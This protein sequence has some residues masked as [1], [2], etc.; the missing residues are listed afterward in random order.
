MDDAGQTIPP[1]YFQA[2]ADWATDALGR[3]DTK[4]LVHCHAGVNRGPSGAFTVL[5]AQGWGV[6][7]APRRSARPVRSP[8]STTPT[9]PS[10]G[11]VDADDAART[12]A[13]EIVMALAQPSAPSTRRFGR[14]GPTDPNPWRICSGHFVSRAWTPYA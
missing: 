2:L 12:A 14:P 5:L 3:P 11:T 13:H 1:D 7:E 8:G 4:L 9:T 6:R 10:T